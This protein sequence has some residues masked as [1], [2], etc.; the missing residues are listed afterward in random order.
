MHIIYLIKSL[1]SHKELLKL[2]NKTNNLIKKLAKDSNSYFTQK[3]SKQLR[4]NLE[5]GSDHWSL[6]LVSSEIA[7][8]GWLGAEERHQPGW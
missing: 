6:E 2:S 4:S 1:Y 5:G 7:D 3:M 8:A